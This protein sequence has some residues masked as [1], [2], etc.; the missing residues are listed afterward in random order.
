M[1]VKINGVTDLVINK[2]DIL[3][4]LSVY[5]YYQDGKLKYFNEDSFQIHLREIIK[6]TCPTV[7]N[8]SFS[9]SPLGI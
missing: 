9:T 2:F 7:K 4:M 8:V 5:R 3:Q 1:A 6:N